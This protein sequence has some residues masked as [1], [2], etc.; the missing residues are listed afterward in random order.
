[1]P[2][3]DISGDPRWKRLGEGL[4]I[5]ISNEL[6]RNHWLDVRATHSAQQA[7]DLKGL[8]AADTLKVAMLLDGTLQSDGET[9]RISAR[10]TNAETRAVIWS[11]KWSGPL[12]DLF[13]IQ[14]LILEQISG[15]LAGHFSGVIASQRR[16]AVAKKPTHSVT[17]FEHYV[18]ASEAKHLFTSEGY[19]ACLEHTRAAIRIDP[20]YA[21]AWAL[22]SI[23]ELWYAPF[24]DSVDEKA[25]VLD[26]MVSNAETAFRLDPD[27]PVA[28]WNYAARGRERIENRQAYLRRAVMLSPS[29]ADDLASSAWISGY[30]ALNGPEPLQWADR[31]LVLNPNPPLW[32]HIARGVAAYRAGNDASAIEAFNRAPKMTESLLFHAAAEWRRGNTEAARRLIAEHVDLAPEKTFS[33]HFGPEAL[34]LPDFQ[35]LKEMA[36]ELGLPLD[37][38]NQ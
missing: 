34:T 38:S 35:D 36:V 9:L 13:K 25:E 8:A 14:D 19:A 31:A 6:A 27:D 12:D 16:R 5:E 22:T 33:D 17:A 37:G 2:F 32:Y 20:E 10:L 18:L 29:N 1:M 4:A 28:L 26:S 30:V 15:S 21:Q 7:A 11:D 23:C 24:T 3:T